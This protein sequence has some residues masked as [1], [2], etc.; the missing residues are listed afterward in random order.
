MVPP[1]LRD[2][3]PERVAARLRNKD[4]GDGLV[5]R[6]AYEVA[7]TITWDAGRV[8]VGWPSPERSIDRRLPLGAR[9]PLLPSASDVL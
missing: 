4:L 6:I 7:R 1:D 2:A 3:V 9:S 8:A 5:H